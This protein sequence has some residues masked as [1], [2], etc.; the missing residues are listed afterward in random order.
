MDLKSVYNKG[1]LGLISQLLFFAGGGWS[2]VEEKNYL[3]A[4][5]WWEVRL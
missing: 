2:V 3:E 4:P 5:S 1:N